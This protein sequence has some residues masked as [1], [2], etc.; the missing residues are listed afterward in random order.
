MSIG[1]FE[2]ITGGASQGE[3]GDMMPLDF[4]KII[5]NVTNQTFV[6]RIKSHGT[7]DNIFAQIKN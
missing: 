3:P 1:V 5:N 6:Y 7:W 4:Q 2:G